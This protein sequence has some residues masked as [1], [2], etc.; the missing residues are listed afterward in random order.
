MNQER[1]MTVIQSPVVSE[2]ATALAEKRCFVFKVIPDATKREIK[3]A[4]ELMFSTDSK[5]ILVEAVR[6]CN[7]KGKKK[8]F[9]QRAGKR[10]D[11]KK[12]YVKLQEGCDIEFMG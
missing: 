2:K 4:V 10:K 6:V 8:V 11:W 5:K 7:V 1:L 3:T 12:A 9:K